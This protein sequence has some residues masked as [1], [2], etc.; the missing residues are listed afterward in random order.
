[1]R[2]IKSGIQ[3]GQE[4]KDRLAQRSLLEKWMRA[5]T[6]TYNSTVGIIAGGVSCH[7]QEKLYDMCVAQV[8]KTTE[9]VRKSRRLEE[10][11]DSSCHGLHLLIV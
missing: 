8:P 3:H 1:M 6:L 2:S 5:S 11:T 7:E 4:T 10:M 9:R